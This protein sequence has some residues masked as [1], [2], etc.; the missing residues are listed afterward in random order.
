MTWPATSIDSAAGTDPA[1]RVVFLTHNFPRFSGDISGAFLVELAQ[2]LVRRDISVR[3]VAPSD[4]GRPG[5]PSVDGIPVRRVRYAGPESETLCYRGTMA[6][7]ARTPRGA[8]LTLKLMRAMRSAVRDELAAGADV[9]HAHWWVPGGLAAP[10]EGRTVLTIHGTDARLLDRSPLARAMARG[11]VHRARVVTTVSSFLADTITRR[12]GR[13]IPPHAVR[14]MPIPEGRFQP[15]SEPGRGLIVVSRL[16]AQKR[17]GLALEA[18]ATLNSAG[19]NGPQRLTIVGD[20]PER[21]GL[22]KLAADLGIAAQVTF[23]GS[24]EPGELPAVLNRAAVM[25]FPAVDEGFGLVAAEAFMCGVAV[26]ACRDGGGTLDVVPESGAGR[27]VEP[28][29]E[30]LA[31]AATELLSSQRRWQEARELGEEW[32][33]R[34]TPGLIAEHCVEW[35]AEAAYGP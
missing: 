31:Q 9:V 22:E 30:S 11:V 20:G 12:T 27:V 8:W 23:V 19:T 35:Y 7:A 18:L 4:K 14:P 6:E 3:V 21:P 5:G 16:T 2:E 34:L 24:V 1:V 10:P 15:G 26:V 33:R 32:R 29:A 13:R 25:L 28:H 17:V